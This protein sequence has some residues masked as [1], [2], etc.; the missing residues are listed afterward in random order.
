MRSP[1]AAHAAAWAW[2]LLS[3]LCAGC[4][5]SPALMPT[6]SIYT[7]PGFDPFASVPP[8]QR[9]NKVEM[10]YVTDREPE[11]GSTPENRRYGYG[12]SRSKAFGVATLQFGPDGLAWD[13]LVRISRTAH[14]SEKT[15]LHIT[16]VRELARFSPTPPKLILDDDEAINWNSL[17]EI[18]HEEAEQKFA[19][20]LAARVAATPRKE[21]FVYVHGFHN[22][23]TDAVF[24]MGEVWHFLGREGV[25]VVYTWP[26]GRPG[27][28]GYAYDRESGEFTVYHL[29]R[30]LRRIAACPG[31]E[32]I[33]VLAHSRGTDVVATAIRELHIETRGVAETQRALKLGTVVLAAADLDVDVVIQRLWAERISR[34]CER[35]VIYVCKDDDALGMANW[36][37]GGEMRLGY[38]SPH[39]FQRDELENLRESTRIQI[40]DAR[41]SNAGDF[42]HNYFHSNPAV[43]SDL[44]LLLRYGLAPGGESGRPLG[45]NE[46][47]FWLLDDHYPDAKKGNWL[48][49]LGRPKPAATTAPTGGVVGAKA[50]P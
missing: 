26:A 13:D 23:F 31:V 39:I 38:L 10:L 43:S 8:A 33:H 41:V 27:L 18:A 34:A 25:P 32:K 11:E 6:P 44:V 50:G 16:S 20:E 49:A 3:L 22:T 19:A 4:G 35:V 24:T 40:I 45:V 7:I 15:E 17:A 1:A 42:G 29:K 21:V 37:F 47:G 14:R 46:S 2:L 28:T 5:S 48:G 9:S 30:T 36:L 12:R